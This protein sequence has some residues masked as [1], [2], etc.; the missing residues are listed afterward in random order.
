M[1]EERNRKRTLSA[2]LAAAVILVF[3]S[4]LLVRL[5]EERR[6]TFEQK[7]ES[8]LKASSP[9]SQ[10]I[11]MAAEGY[12]D[13]IQVWTAVEPDGTV[14]GV[15]IRTLHET[16]GVGRRA[17]RDETF[18]RQ[19]LGTRGNADIGTNVDGLTG[20]TVTSRAV[21]R[22]INAASAAVTGVDAVTEPTTWGKGED[23]YE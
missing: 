11:R 18:L 15:A 17:L 13:E 14:V 6:L 22:A 1:A 5:G 16:P 2:L 3:S 9:D 4:S 7:L 21:A 23:A 20:A 10:V 8:Q 19:F 12:V